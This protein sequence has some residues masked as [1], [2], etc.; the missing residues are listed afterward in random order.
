[1]A[2]AT[3]S[4]PLSNTQLLLDSCFKLPSDEDAA[5][6]EPLEISESL[7]H[8]RVELP[9]RRVR[10]R[11][12]C[13]LTPRVEPIFGPPKPKVA[14]ELDPTI[15]N[16]ER[17]IKMTEKALQEAHDNSTLLFFEENDNNNGLHLNLDAYGIRLYAHYC[18]D[19]M[20]TYKEKSAWAET[21]LNRKING[22]TEG[23]RYARLNCSRWWSRALRSSISRKREMVFLHRGLIGHRNDHYISSYNATAY[24]LMQA[25]Q[26]LWMENTVV[27]HVSGSLEEYLSQKE[28]SRPFILANVVK[29]PEERLAK[30][31]TFVKAMDQLAMEDELQAYM[32]TLTLEPEWHANPQFG[33]KSWNG[34]DPNQGHKHLGELWQAIS[35]DLHG[36]NIGISGLR[37]VEA[38]KD[39]CPHW[40]IWLLARPEAESI[41]QRT[42]M[43]YFPNKLKVTDPTQPKRLKT[44]YYDTRQDVIDKTPRSAKYKKEGAQVDWVH[45]DKRISNGSSYVMKYLFKALN[46]V[47][48][49]SRVKGENP[50]SKKNIAGRKKLKAQ[51]K[52]AERLAA[53]RWLW[54]LNSCQ[55]FGVEKCLTAWD[56]LRKLRTKP[57]SPELFELWKHARGSDKEGR[58]E[59]QRG[60]CYNFLR[61]IGGLTASKAPKELAK[62]PRLGFRRVTE[63]GENIY[64]EETHRTIGIALINRTREQYESTRIN[65]ET[66][67][68]RPVKRWRTVHTVIEEVETRLDEWKLAP[69]PEDMKKE[70]REQRIKLENAHRAAIKK[71]EEEAK[72]KAEAKAAAA[73]TP[74]LTSEPIAAD[75]LA[76][77]AQEAAIALSLSAEA[78]QPF[79]PS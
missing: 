3:H 59:N 10:L 51:Q 40:H 35:R 50:F 16:L 45:I 32:I 62:A 25:R 18:A 28:D 8:T 55:L 49:E 9:S 41:I 69:I 54:G 58:I 1:M 56:E 66:G 52:E 72:A 33:K 57:E 65:M 64:K 71:A 37:V 4:L 12:L 68:I 21:L 46:G 44:R 6:K 78:S 13:V 17:L 5:D 2:T 23:S 75:L 43:K 76:Y 19:K 47:Q 61:A 70:R 11:P 74:A 73:A 24:A 79:C 7:R 34:S 14:I 60:D 42:I 29:S 38:H 48:Y 20:M 22:K 63:T 30:N 67:E 27:N 36:Y 77:Y 53:Y 26:K 39:A 15:T 31:Y